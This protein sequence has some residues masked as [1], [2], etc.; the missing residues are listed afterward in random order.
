MSTHVSRF[1]SLS[2]VFNH[3]LLTKLA[4]S[5]IRANPYAAVGLFGQIHNYTKKK[6]LNKIETLAFGYSSENTQRELSNE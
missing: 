4:T 2:G 1:L 3:I 6:T 5:S